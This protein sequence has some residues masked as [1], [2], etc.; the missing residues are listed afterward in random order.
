MRNN[1]FLYKT[2][3]SGKTGFLFFSL[4]CP[5]GSM[6]FE[7]YGKKSLPL[8]RGINGALVIFFYG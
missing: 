1:V 2:I 8:K 6:F 7:F 5:E 3:L 4:A